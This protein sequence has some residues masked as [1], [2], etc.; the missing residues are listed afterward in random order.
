MKT[1]TRYSDIP[2]NAMFLGSENGDGTMYEG[3]AQAI[4]DATAPVQ[5]IDDT[6]AHYFDLSGFDR[7]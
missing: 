4:E 2:S 1:Y 5:L 6:G 3:L 7:A